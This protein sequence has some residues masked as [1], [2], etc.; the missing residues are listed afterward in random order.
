MSLR[1]LQK[2]LLLER[3]CRKLGPLRWPRLAGDRGY[4]G[5]RCVSD[6][7]HCPYAWCSDQ[8]RAHEERG[9]RHGRGRGQPNPSRQRGLRNLEPVEVLNLPGK[10]WVRKGAL[11]TGRQRDHGGG[12]LNRWWSP[13]LSPVPALHPALVSA[14]TAVLYTPEVRPLLPAQRHGKLDGPWQSIFLPLGQGVLLCRGG[15]SLLPRLSLGD[16]ADLHPTHRGRTCG[17]LRSG[18]WLTGRGHRG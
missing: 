1:L 14:K 6:R 12:A 8:L 18:R 10:G 16:G 5:R 7:H 3:P 2:R 15:P 4:C 17:G 9:E 11:G 13:P